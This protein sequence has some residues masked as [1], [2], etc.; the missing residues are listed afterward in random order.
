MTVAEP[1]WAEKHIFQL[2][3]A[4]HKTQVVMLQSSLVN[5][6]ITHGSDDLP[7][8]S[9]EKLHII[10][11]IYNSTICGFELNCFRLGLNLTLLNYSQM[12]K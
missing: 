11:V 6:I 9:L 5:S 2:F 8:V 4:F 7:V 12:L 3:E 1:G 10:N